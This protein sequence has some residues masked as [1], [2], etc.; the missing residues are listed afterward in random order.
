MIGYMIVSRIIGM[1]FRLVVPLVLIALLG[2]AGAITSLLPDSGPVD[3]YGQ[4]PSVSDGGGIGD[5][6]LRDV[7]DIAVDAA[8]AMLQG[9]LALLGGAEPREAEPPAT[10]RGRPPARERYAPE[11]DPGYPVDRGR[12]YRQQPAEFYP[13]TYGRPYADPYN[14][15]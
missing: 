14:G 4:R 1:A 9:G 5:L 11:H 13:E 7:A 10:I 12:G 2:G 6:R 15:R 8:R 3:R